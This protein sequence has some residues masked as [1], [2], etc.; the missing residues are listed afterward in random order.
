[1]EIAKIKSRKRKRTASQE[2]ENV[3]EEVREE[4][5]VDSEGSYIDVALRS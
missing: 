4:E 2:L 3:I 1:M 5:D